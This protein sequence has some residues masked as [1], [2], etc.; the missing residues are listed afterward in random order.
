MATKSFST[1]YKINGVKHWVL[2]LIVEEKL[3][4][5]ER[6]ETLLS[7]DLWLRDVGSS[8]T[9]K[10]Y[11]IGRSVSINGTTVY[12][13]AR[14]NSDSIS[15]GNGKSYKLAEGSTTVAHNDD[16]TKSIS[17]S[18]SMDMAK[19][20][21]T[22]GPLS[23]SGTMTLTTIARASQPTLSS[24]DFNMGSAITIYTNRKSK[25]F[26]HTVECFNASN[27]RLFQIGDSN[28][29][30][31]R[32]SWNTDNLF[33]KCTNSKTLSGYIKVTTYN[34]STPIGTAKTVNF[35]ATVPDT[36]DY[37]PSAS[38][39]LAP[40]PATIGG[41]SGITEYVQGKSYVNATISATPKKSASMKRYAEM[42]AFT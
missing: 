42:V 10:N 24:T 15:L 1:D 22:P 33:A 8:Y 36:V 32:I 34:G 5:V 20:S 4:N 41:L 29:V 12:N 30:T 26:T 39:T 31:D 6:N 11:N 18:Y 2:E 38:M 9:F 23:G 28:K 16:G 25:A 27:A 3:S 21:Y 7:F 37:R 19:A 13:V 35:K 14:A 40:T 17:V